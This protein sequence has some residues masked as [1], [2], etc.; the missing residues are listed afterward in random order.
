MIDVLFWLVLLLALVMMFV[1]EVVFS[2]IANLKMEIKQIQA[3]QGE[4]ASEN[5]PS[6]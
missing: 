4:Y 3:R 1:I 6:T 5:R 2:R